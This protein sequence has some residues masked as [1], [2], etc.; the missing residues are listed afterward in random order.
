ME[1]KLTEL[2]SRL[3]AAAEENLKAVVLY[4]SAATSEYQSGHS[5]V[6]VLCLL[7]AGRAWRTSKNCTTSPSGG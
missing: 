5:D 7:G 1:T 3:K 6:N 2:V 4:G